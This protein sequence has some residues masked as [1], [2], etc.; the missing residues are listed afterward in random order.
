MVEIWPA[1][2]ICIHGWDPTQLVRGADN[3]TAALEHPDRVHVIRLCNVPGPA[4]QRFSA[5]MQVPFPEL[6]FFALRSRGASATTS[7]LPDSFLGG[8]APSL[9]RFWLDR[10]L[11][12]AVQKL[13]LTTIRLVRLSLTN[14]PHS[15]YISPE[16][17]VTCLSSLTELET[18]ELGFTSPRSRPAQPSPPPPTRVV[19]PVLADVSFRGAGEYLDDVVARV[20]IPRIETL[21]IVLFM[22]LVLHMP[23]FDQFVHR[24]VGLKSPNAARMIFDNRLV[25]I[26][27]N[28]PHGPILEIRCSTID[29]QV[30]SMAMLCSQL[31][32]LLS[33]MERLDLISD[34]FPFEAEGK[35][36][37]E[38][39]QFLE[40]FEP[41]IALQS[42]YVSKNLVPLISPALQEL[43]RVGNIEVL[44]NLR[45]LF[46][47]GLEQSDIVQAFVAA[48]QRSGHPVAV[49]RWETQLG[50]Q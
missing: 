45:D 20:D 43:T 1:L 18:L 21:Y 19:L 25:H 13:L 8:S 38:T 7:A 32:R 24:T 48:R 10:V 5:A 47:G 34:Y 42:L 49:H 17:M 14:I 9:Q 2:P 41:F 29:W 30:S 37:M 33:V 40:L 23:N 26:V 46:L 50:N 12:P 11:Y 4:F 31:S 39:M 15:G 16:A 3:I 28:P 44:L 35:D 22:G 27:L 36:D 6:T